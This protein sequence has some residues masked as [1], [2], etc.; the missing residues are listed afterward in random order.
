MFKIEYILLGFFEYWIKLLIERNVCKNRWMKWKYMFIVRVECM[1]V[2]FGRRNYVVI[3]KML[4][5]W[6]EIW[7]IEEREYFN[8]DFLYV[9]NVV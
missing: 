5:M 7:N 6:F 3:C 4:N 2:Y 9:R 1:L 8:I